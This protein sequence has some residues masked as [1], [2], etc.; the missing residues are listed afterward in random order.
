[1]EFKTAVCETEKKLDK[2]NE[3][4]K[5]KKTSTVAINDIIPESHMNAA[6]GREEEGGNFANGF[7][8]Y[9]RYFRGRG[10]RGGSVLSRLA[11]CS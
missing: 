11:S 7:F 4:K 1:L 5:K 8:V 3:E 10:G 2:L 6:G 9:V